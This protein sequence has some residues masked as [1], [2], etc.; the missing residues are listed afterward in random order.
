[1]C[2]S[3]EEPI[4]IRHTDAVR[5]VSKKGKTNPLYRMENDQPK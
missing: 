5:V 2:R 4:Q 3:H 1:M